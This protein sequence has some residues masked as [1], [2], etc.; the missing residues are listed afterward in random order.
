MSPTNGNRPPNNHESQGTAFSSQPRAARPGSGRQKAPRK[1]FSWARLLMS[2][3]WLVILMLLFMLIRGIS[4]PRMGQ[5]TEKLNVTHGGP[6]QASKDEPVVSAIPSDASNPPQPAP[7]PS[8]QASESGE[9]VAVAESYS[10]PPGI[11]PPPSQAMAPPPRPSEPRIAELVLT[12]S[13][14]GNFYARGEI[15]HQSVLF[16]VD[17]GASAVS[18]PDKLRHA[19]QLTRGR[20]LQSATANGVAGMFETRVKALSIGPL[21]LKD[22][23]AVLNPGAP[24]DTVLLGMTALREVRMVQHNGRMS[25][26]QEVPP[27]AGEQPS[28]PPPPKMKKSVKD[29][30]GGDKVINDRVLKC[31][32]GLDEEEEAEGREA[33]AAE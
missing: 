24:D 32:Q 11:A 21:R 25:L 31:M 6:R 23:P 22:V 26:Q 15:N 18:I 13:A 19:L 9:A 8:P 29:C 28:A 33:Q 3:P 27:D 4:P 1:G 7:E 12:P 30:M 14:N 2:V 16:V 10:P 5:L 20:Y 17:T